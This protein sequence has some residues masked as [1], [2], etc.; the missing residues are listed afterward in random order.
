MTSLDHILG[1]IEA[2]LQLVECGNRERP[3]CMAGFLVVVEVQRRHSNRL[4]LG[5]RNFPVSQIRPPAVRAAE[6]DQAAGAP[7]RFWPVHVR[8]FSHGGAHDVTS[9]VPASRHTAGITTG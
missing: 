5:F 3:H 1:P 2:T 8:L 9:F 4:L 7:D 6:A